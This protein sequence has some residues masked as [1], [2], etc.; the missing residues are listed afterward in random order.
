M[1]N[2]FKSNSRFSALMGETSS[3]KDVKK[4][5][6][7]PK[8][9]EVKIQKDKKEQDKEEQDKKEDKKEDKFNS[10]KS[11]RVRDTNFRYNEKDK[12]KERKRIEI[13][14]AYRKQK[15]QEEKEKLLQES[16]NMNN[17]PELI[18]PN[19]K[20]N[21][22]ENKY[23]NQS[24]VDKLKKEESNKTNNFD[25]DLVNLKPG[26]V[27]LKRDLKSGETLIKH[28]PDAEFNKKPLKSEKRIE[29]DIL[30]ALVKLHKKRTF[31]YINNYGYDDWE[32]NFKFP[33]W[34]EEEAYLDAMEELANMT[35]EDDIEYE[36]DDYY[37]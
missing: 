11:E 6:N 18:V 33:N 15:E 29:I 4:E 19:K 2:I 9:S 37:E 13:E 8:P 21:Q 10:F 25:N 20:D 16:L 17:F 7:K 22:N 3:K 30:N 28:H 1:S 36:E 26:W 35:D 23:S 12:Q 27:I 31:E 5:K 14:E 32:K 34:R 24:Y